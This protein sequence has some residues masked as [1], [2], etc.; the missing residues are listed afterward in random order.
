MKNYWWVAV[1]ALLCAGQASAQGRSGIGDTALT[2]VKPYR[3]LQ[4][5]GACLA[6]T[7]RTQALA[8]I[9]TVPDSKEEAQ[10]L[11]KWVYGEHEICMFG[12]TN[13]QM[14]GIFARGAIA[15][16]L[17][18]TQGVPATHRLSSPSPSEVRDLH[19]VARCYTS[20]HRNEV[21]AL[22]K[23]HPGSQE[24]VKAVAALWED[25]RKCMPKFQVRLNAPW[26]R[27]L[28][29]EALLRIEPNTVASGD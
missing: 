14:S 20:G 10:L 9:A 11:K 4:A 28:L 24:E 1:V 7:Q 26:I 5:F 29:A 12:G 27:F 2:N 13:M 22:M 16:G 19:G 6:R 15:E 21:E 23:I 3:E 17:L 25:F 8:L 18:R